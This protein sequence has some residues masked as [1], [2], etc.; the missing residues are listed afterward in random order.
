MMKQTIGNGLITQD[1][2]LHAIHRHIVDPAFKFSNL[3]AA[4]PLFQSTTDEFVESWSQ[5]ITAGGGTAAAD[6]YLGFLKLT[7]DII[8]KAAFGIDFDSISGNLEAPGAQAAAALLG[9]QETAMPPT[10]QMLVAAYPSLFSVVAKLP[11]GP[12]SKRIKV[13]QV[14]DDLVLSVI[15]AKRDSRAAGVTRGDGI[16]DMLDL[17]LEGDSQMTNKEMVDHV[18]TVL[19]AGH[20]TTTSLL[21]FLYLSLAGEPEMLARVRKEIKEVVGDSGEL[22]FED[23]NK[24]VYLN[25]LMRE[26]LRMYSPVAKVARSVDQDTMLKGHFLPAGTN[27]DVCISALQM[28]PLYWPNPEKFDPERWMPNSPTPAS[29]KAYIPFIHGTRN[30]VGSKF[31]QVHARSIA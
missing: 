10:M 17:L 27:V 3:K 14:M 16:T 1:R 12:A 19:F 23:L 6:I 11:I 9:L 22:R 26:T 2:T 28:D 8:G 24:L 31:F 7:L 4:F 18:K 21:V 20:N 30:C 29:T 13:L 15:N 25:A 5:K